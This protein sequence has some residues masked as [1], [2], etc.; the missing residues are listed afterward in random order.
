MR[1]AGLTER[2]YLYVNETITEVQSIWREK[3]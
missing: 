2:A 1:R 3:I